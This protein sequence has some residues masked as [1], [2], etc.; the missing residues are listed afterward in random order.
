MADTSQRVEEG[1]RY[2]V[3]PRRDVGAA[4]TALS[5]DDLLRLRAS[6]LTLCSFGSPGFRPP[7]RTSS[8]PKSPTVRAAMAR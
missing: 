5:E 3:Q 8:I 6:V 2:G 1:G 4:L 7:M